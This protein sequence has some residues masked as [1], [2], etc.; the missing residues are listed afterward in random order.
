MQPQ[1]SSKLKVQLPVYDPSSN[2][3]IEEKLAQFEHETRKEL[4]LDLAIDKEQWNDTIN[5]DFFATSESTPRFLF[6]ADHGSR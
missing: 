3:Q 2:A 4:G 1:T 6:P 5:R